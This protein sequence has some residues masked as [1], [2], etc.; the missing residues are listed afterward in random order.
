MAFRDFLLSSPQ[1]FFELGENLAAVQHIVSFWR[2][3]VPEGSR[4][5]LD[6]YEFHGMLLDFDSGLPPVAAPTQAARRATG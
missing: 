3:R 1:R 5:L 6:P 2:Y 4:V